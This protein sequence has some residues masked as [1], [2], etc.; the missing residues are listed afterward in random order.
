MAWRGEHEKA[1][2]EIEKAGRF[3]VRW[4]QRRRFEEAEVLSAVL[5]GDTDRALDLLEQLI[6]QPGLLTV[7]NL[8]L[9]PVY[10][11]LRSNPRFQ[12]LLAKG[13]R[14]PSRQ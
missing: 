7:W 12:V 1:A 10:K 3:D 8:R 4:I 14:M 5:A 9:D 6:P 13:V 11:P 2:L